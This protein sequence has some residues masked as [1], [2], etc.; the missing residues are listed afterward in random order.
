MVQ[1]IT[2]DTI[3]GRHAEVR[4]PSVQTDGAQKTSEQTRDMT[5]VCVSHNY[6]RVSSR[7]LFSN[8]NKNSFLRVRKRT[9]N[10]EE[11]RC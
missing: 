7:I 9:G 3:Q 5:A 10:N 6:R 8:D 4:D 1:Q 2:A 11:I